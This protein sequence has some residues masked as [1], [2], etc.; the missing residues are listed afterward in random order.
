MVISALTRTNES[1]KC[2]AH[3][4]TELVQR[5]HHGRVRYRPAGET[6]STRKYEVAPI[7]SDTIARAFIEG[8]HYSR[9]YPAARFRYGIF[10][11][12]NLVGVAVFSMPCNERAL[13]CLPG[14]RLERVELGRFVLDAS[15]EANGESWFIARAFEHLRAEGITGVLSFA[16]PQQRTDAAGEVIFPGHIGTIYQATNATYLG[17]ATP[18]TLR[19]LPDGTVLNAR[20]IQKLLAGEQGWRYVRDQM[21]RHGADPLHEASEAPGW[22]REQLPRITRALRHGGNHRYAWALH[23]RDRRHLPPSQPYP[24]WSP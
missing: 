9:S 8:N 3:M 19:L 2:G 10:Q 18:R 16:D 14:E 21:I 20:S 15:V 4:K 6:I 23:R 17:R 24:K 1:I 12:E 7:A 11:G 13:Q 5:W 22:L